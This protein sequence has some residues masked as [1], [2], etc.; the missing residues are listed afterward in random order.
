MKVIQI[1]RNQV[2]GVDLLIG[3]NEHDIK[4]VGTGKAEYS[5]EFWIDLINEA[6]N[7]LDMLK[8]EAA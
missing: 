8:G 3:N 5:E 6:R 4:Y 2:G 7:A 1:E